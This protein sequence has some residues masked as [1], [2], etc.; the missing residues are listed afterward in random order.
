MKIKLQVIA[1]MTLYHKNTASP[2]DINNIIEK[3]I[4]DNSEE[5]Q[6]I[7]EEL[8]SQIGFE[9]EVNEDDFD[10][11]VLSILS[12]TAKKDCEEKIEKIMSAFQKSILNNAKAYAEFGGCMINLSD[13][14]MIMIKKFVVNIS[15]K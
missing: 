15:K 2:I 4:D 6:E 3:E 12:E 7:C 9:R 14:C 5:Y 8:K 1:S 13:F 11:H 10:K